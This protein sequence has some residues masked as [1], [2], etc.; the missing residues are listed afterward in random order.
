MH[1]PLK[2]WDREAGEGEEHFQSHHSALF[3]PSGCHLCTYYVHWALARDA[4]V[5]R[6]DRLRGSVWSTSL[7]VIRTWTPIHVCLYKSG[8]LD[9]HLTA[10]RHTWR[11]VGAQL[12]HSLP[13]REKPLSSSQ[14]L[15][16]ALPHPRELLAQIT[17]WPS[18]DGAEPSR[19]LME[20]NRQEA[21]PWGLQEFE[22]WLW[23]LLPG[24]S[25]ACHPLSLYFRSHKMNIIVTSLIWSEEATERSAGRSA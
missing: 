24:S 6:G 2:K 16:P 15:S 4:G 12:M 20:G 21:C 14:G 9:S 13:L 10:L 22:A 25:W 3:P 1:L 8:D 19:A 17:K 18:L 7:R 11:L 23:H 5:M